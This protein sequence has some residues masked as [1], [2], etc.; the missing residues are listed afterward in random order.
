MRCGDD[1]FI[2]ITD[3]R[4]LHAAGTSALLCKRVLILVTAP[5]RWHQSIMVGFAILYQTVNS[6]EKKKVDRPRL[7]KV[8]S[9]M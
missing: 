2:S 1:L 4:M 6:S 9:T 5:D 7:H 3:K 8:G